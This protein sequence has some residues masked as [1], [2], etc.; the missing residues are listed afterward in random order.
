M[1]TALNQF[2]LRIQ[3]KIIRQALRRLGKRMVSQ[4]KS[5]ITWKSK[6]LKRAIKA[7]VKTYK[8]GKIIW[9]G[10]GVPAGDYDDWRTPVKAYAY[11]KG[12]TPYPK[13]RPTNRKGRGW[14]KGLRR[15]GGSKIF[16]T[17][18]ISKVRDQYLNTAYDLVY[19]D[20][21]EMIKEQ[22]G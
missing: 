9:M 14:R 18:F 1:Q 6:K 10:V 5:N 19:K 2:Q 4:M 16:N 7:K 3:R 22:N 8:R 13:G 11:D 17:R 21:A 12:F 15:I 20:I